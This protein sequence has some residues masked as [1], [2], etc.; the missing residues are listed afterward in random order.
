LEKP[1]RSFHREGF[2]FERSHAYGEYPMSVRNKGHFTLQDAI[3]LWIQLGE[4]SEPTRSLPF[5]NGYS[6]L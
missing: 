5:K 6:D 3:M 2:S 1:S 4:I